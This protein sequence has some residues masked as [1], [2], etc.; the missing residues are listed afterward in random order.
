MKLKDRIKY[1][2]VTGIKEGRIEEFKNN[3]IFIA[4]GKGGKW[5]NKNNVIE[6][7]KK[8]VNNE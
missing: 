1:K 8:E 7:I 3:K 6:V 4:T 2:T 5:I